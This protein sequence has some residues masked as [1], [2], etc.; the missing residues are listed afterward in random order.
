MSNCSNCKLGSPDQVKSKGGPVYNELFDELKPYHLEY[1]KTYFFWGNILY[2][3]Q[4]QNSRCSLILN[5][6]KFDN[7]QYLVQIFLKNKPSLFK[8]LT[9]ICLNDNRGIISNQNGFTIQ[10]T[11]VDQ[12]LYFY[13]TNS[14]DLIGKF[15]LEDAMLRPPGPPGLKG[16]LSTCGEKGFYSCNYCNCG[17]CTKSPYIGGNPGYIKTNTSCSGKKTKYCSSYYCKCA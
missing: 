6:D 13:T 14:N 1:D 5:K 9:G 8:P 15:I 4:T 16:N 17:Q 11:T 10:Y 2:D 7:V 12:S 3:K